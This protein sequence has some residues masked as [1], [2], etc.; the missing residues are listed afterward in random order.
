MTPV[1]QEQSFLETQYVHEE[2]PADTSRVFIVAIAAIT[3]TTLFMTTPLD[4]AI[5]F[6]VVIITVALLMLYSSDKVENVRHTSMPRPPVVPS[7]EEPYSTSVHVNLSTQPRRPHPFVTSFN[8]QSSHNAYYRPEEPFPLASHRKEPRKNIGEGFQQPPLS[9]HTRVSNSSRHVPTG[10]SLLG[11]Q[12]KDMPTD[13]KHS[14]I[15]DIP[16]NQ[17]GDNFDMSLLETIKT[18]Q[19]YTRRNTPRPPQQPSSNL[20]KGRSRGSHIVPT[21]QSLTGRR[22]DDMPTDQKSSWDT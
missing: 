3:A 20:P 17:G 22:I 6:T 15:T 7:R 13:Q 14:W 1:G 4:V 2:P 19:P 16:G 21:G 8:P 11:R 18:T 12:T 9:T 5:T 10:E